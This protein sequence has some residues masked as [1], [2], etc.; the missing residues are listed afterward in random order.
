MS[1]EFLSRQATVDDIPAIVRHRC[2]MFR[3]M[4]QLRDDY[5]NALAEASAKYLAEAIPSGEYIGWLVALSEQPHTI[6]AGGGMQL[7][8]MLPRPDSEG[9]LL[10]PGPQGLVVNV[11]TEKRWRRKGLAELVMRTIIE[12]SRENRVASLVLHASSMGRPLYER[13]GFVDTN[14]MI[15]P[16]L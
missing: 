5:Y 9:R 14:E 6:V 3:D 1:E 8:R 7:R 2:E 10:R 11:Y 13:M 12:W 15:Y 16:L 4:G